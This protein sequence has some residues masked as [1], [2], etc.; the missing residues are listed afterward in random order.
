MSDVMLEVKNLK[1]YFKTAR[2]NVHAV[3]DV[4]FEI[5]KGEVKILSEELVSA[6]VLDKDYDFEKHKRLVPMQRG[7]VPITFA[8]TTDLEK[9]F[10]FKPRTPLRE[11]LKNFAK[12]YKEFYKL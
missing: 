4:N 10:N 1:K 7:D 2:G 6:D 11:G 8:D 3:D 5:Y 12:W 9:D